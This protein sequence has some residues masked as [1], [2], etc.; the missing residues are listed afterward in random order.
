[1]ADTVSSLE[2]LIA[3]VGRVRSGAV[4]GDE[5][6][7]QTLEVIAD[8][9]IALLAEVQKPPRADVTSIP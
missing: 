2:E 6:T 5:R 3:R 7:Q 8:A 1:M 4:R 9:L